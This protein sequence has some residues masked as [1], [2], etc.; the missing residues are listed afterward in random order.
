MENCLAKGYNTVIVTRTNPDAWSSIQASTLKYNI[1]M[2]TQFCP[3]C[4]YIIFLKKLTSL[5]LLVQVC[6]VQVFVSLFL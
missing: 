2:S 4:V 1:I 3:S 5:F 6:S